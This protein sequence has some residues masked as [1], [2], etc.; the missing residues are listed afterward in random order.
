M[1]TSHLPSPW[2]CGVHLSYEYLPFTITYGSLAFICLWIPAIY[3]HY[4]SIAFICLM[5]TCHLP[6]PWKCGVHLSYAY[7]LFT[8][9]ME[10][11]RSSV[12]CLPA[13]YLH[14]GSVTVICHIPTRYL[15][16]LRK[17]DVHLSYKY[18]PFTIT[19]EA[20]RSSV[21]WTPPIYHHH[22]SVAV[23]CNMNAS[24]LPSLRKFDVQLSYTYRPITFTLEV[25]RSSV[26]CL[27]AIYLHYGSVAKLS[28]QTESG[29]TN[30]I[31]QELL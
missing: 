19:M 11:W 29:S 26:I 15:P 2:K 24:H 23:S 5:P 22:G 27:P 12:I 8:I 6:S 16:S 25:W 13:I 4:L 7:L 1:N 28:P 31:E 18:L 9:T 17:C 10:V 21:L 14:Y 30:H 3:P 20:W